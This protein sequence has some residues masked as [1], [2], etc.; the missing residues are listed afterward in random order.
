MK[1]MLK[2]FAVTSKN[3][4][5]SFLKNKN[6]IAMT[7]FALF[8]PVLFM[9]AAGS[10]EVARYALIMQKMDRITAT[11]SDLVAR[12]GNEAMSE[13]EISNILDS[14]SYMARPFDFSDNSLIVIT[15]VEGRASQAPIILSQRVSGSLTGV[16]SSIGDG[17]DDDATLPEAF[18]DVGS[19]ETLSDGETLVVAEFLYRYTPYLTG[20][21][22]F[23]DEM[24]LYRDA[25]FRPRFTDRIEFPSGS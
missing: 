1:R 20:D 23:F 22:G 3:S 15:S 24:I 21:L 16:G 9:I 7:E 12:S 10:F 19:G 17:E 25:Y 13:L 4:F 14:A 2:K 18:P 6:G 8:A 11:L 5:S